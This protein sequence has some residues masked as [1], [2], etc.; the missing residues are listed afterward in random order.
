MKKCFFYQMS[1]PLPASSQNST[2]WKITPAYCTV[3][4]VQYPFPVKHRNVLRCLRNFCQYGSTV[5]HQKFKSAEMFK[6]FCFVLTFN[7]ICK[8]FR[9]SDS[10]HL[11]YLSRGFLENCITS[12]SKITQIST[13]GIFP[14]LLPFKHFEF[15]YF[16]NL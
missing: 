9:F 12:C 6:T 3:Y 8:F 5:Y 14:H 11:Y 13:V 10:A 7:D 15:L 1:R 16:R 4:T 2:T